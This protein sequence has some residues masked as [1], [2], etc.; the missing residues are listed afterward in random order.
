VVTAAGFELL[1]QMSRLRYLTLGSDEM[2][3][4]IPAELYRLGNLQSLPLENANFEGK[5]FLLNGT[6][7][8]VSLKGNDFYAKRF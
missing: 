7:K 8:D 5:F 4:E 1:T 2:G 6:I 3:G